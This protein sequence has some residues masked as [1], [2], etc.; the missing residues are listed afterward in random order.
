MKKLI[1]QRLSQ[2]KLNSIF[3][4]F[5][6]F[7]LSANAQITIQGKVTDK[8]GAGIL[9]VSVTLKNTT[10]GTATDADGNYILTAS[11]NPGNHIVRFTA[12]GYKTVEQNVAIEGNKTNC[13]W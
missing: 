1:H 7:M 8:N 9:A 3:I 11:I 10:L 2:W 4:F 13:K 12:V 5:T 6:F